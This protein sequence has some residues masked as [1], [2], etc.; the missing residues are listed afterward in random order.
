MQTT[1]WATALCT[2]LMAGIYLAF[3][4]F[5]MGSLAAMPKAQ[6]ILAMQSINRVILSSSFMLLFWLSTL[7][8]LGLGAWGISQW[9][10]SGAGYLV[11]GGAVYVLGMFVCTAAFNV[12][13]NNA[14]D[15]V[16]P[17]TAA[18][19]ELWQTYLRNW[20]RYNHVRTVCSAAAS[21]LFVAAAWFGR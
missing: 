18:A 1:I 7:A 3:S 20:T 21:A 4:S 5:V 6:G 12:P 11:A 16:D 10:A 2:A 17:T 15:A 13:L 8:S 19:A 14:L 9:G